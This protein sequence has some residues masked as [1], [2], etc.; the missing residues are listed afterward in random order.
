MAVRGGRESGEM[1]AAVGS[2]GF[3]GETASRRLAFCLLT[4]MRP[5][6]FTQRSERGRNEAETQRAIANEARQIE[7][8]CSA[9]LRLANP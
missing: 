4:A 3:A 6:R 8:A 1:A 7:E 9:S 2:R 5:W